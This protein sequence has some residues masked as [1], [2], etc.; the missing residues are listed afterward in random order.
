M[1]GHSRERTEWDRLPA[2]RASCESR[3]KSSEACLHLDFEEVPMVSTL[4]ELLN[5][6]ATDACFLL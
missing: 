1:V 2:N 6:C 4:T 5:Q 3:P